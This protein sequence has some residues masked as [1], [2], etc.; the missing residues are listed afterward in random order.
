MPPAI[1]SFGG[2]AA[3]KVEELLR[4][5]ASDL[6]TGG[7]LPPLAQQLVAEKHS[8][9]PHK[10]S[11]AQS[12]GLTSKMKPIC[13]IASINVGEIKGMFLKT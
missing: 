5:P 8:Q 3:S 10:T 12:Q 11:F 7:Q 4:D 6:R 9:P 13:N 1:R 2:S